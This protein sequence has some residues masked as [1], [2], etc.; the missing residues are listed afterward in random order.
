MEYDIEELRKKYGIKPM[1]QPMGSSY[2]PQELQN[3]YFNQNQDIQNIEQPKQ[4]ETNLAQDISI[5]LGK[6]VLKTAKG[7]GTLGTKYFTQP[8]EKGINKVFGFDNTQSN[9]LPIYQ[10]GTPQE[11]QAEELLKPEN[12]GEKIGF[13][14]EKIAEFLAPSSKVSKVESTLTGLVKGAKPLARGARTLIRSGVEAGAA[15]GTVA[16]QEGGYDDKVKTAAIV[17]ALFPVAGA[18]LTEGKKLTGDVLQ[19]VG[20]KIQFN[21]IRP[22][23]RDVADGF[24]VENIQKYNLGGSLKGTAT[25]VHV[26]LNDLSNQ[27]KDKLKSSNQ[28]VN[29]N[30][31][32]D[33]TIKG[34]QGD[35]KLTFG[36]NKAIQRVISNLKDEISEVAGKN[37]LVDP[38]EATLIKRGAGTKGSWAFG[39]TEPDANATEKVYSEFYKQIKNAIEKN[40][41][42][43]VAEINKQISD[44]IPISNAVIRRLPVD[45]RNNVIGLTDSIGLYSSMFDP[46]SLALLGANKLSKSGK[47]ANFLVNTAERLKKTDVSKTQVGK[48]IFGK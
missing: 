33:D 1:G 35:K 7:L 47:F 5:G 4:K 20:S 13:G 26:K 40:S 38:Y 44:L 10:K 21:V 43:E 24:K 39:R 45:Q 15:A 2:S 36:D 12:T 48:R 25:K 16:T 29:L 3:K 11:Q 30:N 8:L 32:F 6:G 14:A 27:L 46:R 23:Q 17:A 34:L 42:K 19:N 22:S 37:G 31:V 9:V 41:P 18:G 28:A